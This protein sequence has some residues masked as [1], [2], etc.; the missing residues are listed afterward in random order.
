MAQ[1]RAL[2]ADP[3][4]LGLPQTERALAG[5]CAVLAEAPWTITSADLE[6]LRAAGLSDA[7]VL[8]AVA[9]SSFFNY[10]NRVAD[11]VDIEF[12]YESPLPRISRV[13]REP[14]VRPERSDWPRRPPPLAMKLS[15]R[16]GTLEPFVRWRAYVLERD[17]PL[18]RRDRRVLARAAAAALCDAEGVGTLDDGAPRDRREET[19]AAFSTTLTAAPWRLD[20]AR[21]EQLRALGLDDAGLLDAISVASFQNTASRLNLVLAE[22]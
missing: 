9:L 14:L 8:H 18:S 3:R 1:P 10:L 12:D 7:S 11:A 15:E 16:P 2:L 5:F 6:P 20:A 19:L 17:A 21:L 13:E 22:V 4:G